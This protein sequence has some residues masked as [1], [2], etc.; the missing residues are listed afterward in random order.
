MP[1]SP[2]LKYLAAVV[3]LILIVLGGY[4]LNNRQQNAPTPQP[5]PAV[6]SAS[7]AASPTPLTS[8]FKNQ[9]LQLEIPSGWTATAVTNRPWAV[10]IIKDKYILYIN[11]N[12]SQ[13]SG[14]TG[15]RFAEIGQGAPSVDAVLKSWPSDPC[16]PALTSDVSGSRFY[17]RRADL[18][19]S[20]GASSTCSAPSS[21]TAWYFSYLTDPSNRYFNYYQANQNPALVVTMSY[22]ASTVNQ[23]PKK[24]DPALVSML[25][26][27]TTIAGSLVIAGR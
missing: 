11:T 23:L 1:S 4:W 8:T 7:P 6:S 9:Y 20:A 22:Q 19:V 16:S 17:S 26:Q 14:V 12:A 25:S 15:G 24:D 18:Y 2:N 27:M 3:I 13:A 21:G 10:N 5:S